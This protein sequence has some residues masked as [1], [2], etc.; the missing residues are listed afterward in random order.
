MK[1]RPIEWD[2]LEDS[3]KFNVFIVSWLLDDTDTK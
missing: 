3:I 2:G 1:A